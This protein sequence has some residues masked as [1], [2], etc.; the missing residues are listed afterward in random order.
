MPKLSIITPYKRI[1]G[2]D[3]QWEV[4]YVESL[5]AQTSKDFEL[6]VVGDIWSARG[7]GSIPLFA[8]Q[9]DE[10]VALAVT[11]GVK[12]SCG[13]YLS[14]LPA[15]DTL[16]PEFVRSGLTALDENSAASFWVP[17]GA[18]L[19]EDI[20]M[21][22]T[23]CGAFMV[24]REIWNEVGGFIQSPDGNTGMEDWHFWM[25]MYKAG[26]I[27]ITDDRELFFWRRHDATSTSGKLI[28]TDLMSAK[29][30]WMKETL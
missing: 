24:R 21:N 13:D 12:F 15:N 9:S 6:I 1:E 3:P 8:A 5:L 10:T 18:H 2:H 17:N 28:G 16:H 30:K 27:G 4:E 11:R 29:I 7:L 20:L 19:D 23:M 22:S 26:H 14:V 25:R